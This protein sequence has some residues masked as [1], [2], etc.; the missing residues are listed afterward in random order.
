MKVPAELIPKPAVLELL[1]FPSYM[2][3][4][5]SFP[6]SEVVRGEYPL[7]AEKIEFR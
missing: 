2:D 4:S 5:V 3:G 1:N 6:L 7:V